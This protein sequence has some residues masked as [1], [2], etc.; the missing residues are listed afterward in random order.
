MS[1]PVRSRVLQSLHPLH[2]SREASVRTGR[3]VNART[4]RESERASQSS[5]FCPV[6]PNCKSAT[7]QAQRICCREK[8]PGSIISS[9]CSYTYT[10]KKKRPA[11]RANLLASSCDLLRAGCRSRCPDKHMRWSVLLRQL[12]P[13]FKGDRIGSSPQPTTSVALSVQFTSPRPLKQF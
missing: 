8:A 6:L 13:F 5:C 12:R 11:G 1:R 10:R 9:Y 3:V 4:D 2:F 7:P